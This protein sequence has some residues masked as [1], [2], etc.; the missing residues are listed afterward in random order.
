MAEPGSDLPAGWTSHVDTGGQ[1]YFKNVETGETT[2]DRP[3]SLPEGWSA[4]QDEEGRIFYSN[5]LTGE[6]KWERPAPAGTPLLPGGKM[7]CRHLLVKYA[8]SSNPISRRT[9]ESTAGLSAEAAQVD[10][11]QYADAIAA[12]GSS[13][14]V[15][16][17]YA[18]ERSDCSSY[19]MGGDLEEFL[20]G[21]SGMPDEFEAA[22]LATPVGTVSGIVLSPTGYHL[23]FRTG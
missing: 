17:K 15:F 20:S 23:I 6:S 10:L 12:E 14:E 11:Q 22:V 3:E 7:R 19:A 5:A 4:H 16:A 13:E 21:D 9:G 1:I 18:M 8:G 2:F